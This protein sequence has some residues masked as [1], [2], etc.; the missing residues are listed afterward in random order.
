MTRHRSTLSPA[1]TSTEP[2][3]GSTTVVNDI[4]SR[5]NPTRAVVLPVHSFDDLRAAVVGAR[6][7]RISVAGGRHAMGGQQFVTEGTVLDTRGMSRVLQLD[8]QRGLVEVEAGIQWPELVNHLQTAQRDE[9]EQ[10]TIAQKQTGANR[11]TVGGSVSANC[12]GRGLTMGPIVRDVESLSVV[13]A[14]GALLTCSRKSNSELFSLVIGGYGLFGAIYSITLRLVRREVLERVVEVITVD[15]LVEGVRERVRAGFRYGD[16]QFGIDPDSPDFLHRGVFSCYRPVEAEQSIPGRQR[17]LGADDWQALLQ[18]AHQDKSRAFDLYA[19][20]YLATSGQRYWS[21][22]HQLAVYLDDYH[23]ELDRRLGATEPGTEMISEVYVPRQ[24]LTDFMAAAA[25]ELRAVGADLI[26]GT[27]RFTEADQ[28]T[29][30][31]WA[32]QAYACVVFNL[33]T[34]HTAAGIERSGTAF[35]R[36]IDLAVERDGSYYLTYHRWARREQLLAC[37]PQFGHFLA[38]K[39]RYDPEELFQSDW[40]ADLRHVAHHVSGS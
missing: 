8:R 10:W 21:D 40:Y 15:G 26:Y 29:Y 19:Q 11:F 27:V 31:P 25:A 37:Y 2:T 4:H 7:G 13:T 23:D 5:L 1:F 33:H 38:L 24:R 20:H 18:L 3:S 16:F 30:L 28:D 36:L 6:S 22:D 35:R 12:H 39:R 9:P 34:P 17:A 14:D 32:R